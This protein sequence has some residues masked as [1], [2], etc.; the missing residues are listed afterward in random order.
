MTRSTTTERRRFPRA[1]AAAIALLPLAACQPVR[2]EA[3]TNIPRPLLTPI[4]VTIGLYL[5]EEFREYVHKEERWSV[6]W[7]VN[8]GKAQTDGITRLVNAMFEQVVMLD[9]IMGAIANPDIRAIIEPQLEQYSF[10]TPRDA[11]AE[12]Y[13]VSLKYRVG[14]YTP[15][16]KLVESWPFTGYGSVEASGFGGEDPLRKATALAMRDAGAKLAVEFRQ[17]AMVRGLLPE[18]AADEPL[19]GGLTRP[20]VE[21][22]PIPAAPEEVPESEAGEEPAAGDEEN[23]APTG[24]DD[25]E[26]LPTP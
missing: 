18:A 25:V 16:G 26:P 10:V 11:G 19:P 13:A 6:E 4:P 20:T 12:F 5:P 23:A 17:Q 3:T 1:L 22:E 2:F 8:L 9:G 21:V 24:S 14:L 7:E 15:D